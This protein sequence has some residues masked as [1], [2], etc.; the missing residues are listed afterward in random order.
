MP[1]TFTEMRNIP[2]KRGNGM[3]LQVEFL[4]KKGGYVKPTLVITHMSHMT[5]HTKLLKSERLPSF[6]PHRLPLAENFYAQ[7]V[8]QGI[9]RHNPI[10]RWTC[11]QHRW[12]CTEVDETGMY[13]KSRLQD[14][15]RRFWLMA[16]FH[17][18]FEP[19]TTQIY[20][21]VGMP[22]VTS[23]LGSCSVVL[24]LSEQC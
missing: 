9:F 20:A 7:V 10:L 4:M 19:I 21:F 16:A 13:R 8:L 22:A 24:G 5:C 18:H 6:R 11:L 17:S 23:P 2:D 15:P 3:R 1:L 12:A 14:L